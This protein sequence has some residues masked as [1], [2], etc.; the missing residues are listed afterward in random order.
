VTGISGHVGIYNKYK[1]LRSLAISTNFK[2]YGPYGRKEGT[3]FSVPIDGG[4]IVDFHGRLGEFMDALG[5]FVKPI[6]GVLCANIDKMC[7]A[8]TRIALAS[9]S[10]EA[11]I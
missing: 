8:V 1:V 2:V 3:P 9:P 7:T 6:G 4:V 10:Q 5:I 11:S